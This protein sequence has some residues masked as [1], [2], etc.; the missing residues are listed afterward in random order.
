VGDSLTCFINIQNAFC[1]DSSDIDA[2]ADAGDVRHVG[3][4]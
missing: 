1:A 2:D 3:S 4:G